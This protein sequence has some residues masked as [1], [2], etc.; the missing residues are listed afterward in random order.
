MSTYI[1]ISNLQYPLYLEDI[2]EN[3]EEYAVVIPSEIPESGENQVVIEE[4]PELIDG[5][6]HQKWIV[7]DMTTEEIL[8]RSVFILVNMTRDRIISKEELK[9][10]L[11]DLGLTENQADSKLLLARH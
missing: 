10:Q 3:E 1:K 9:A 8:E 4:S 2:L 5:Q 11:I 6:W 7:R